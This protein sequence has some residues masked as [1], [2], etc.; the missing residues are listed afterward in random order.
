M[1]N[2]G[3]VRA[4]RSKVL[5]AYE[6]LDLAGKDWRESEQATRVI[7]AIRCGS[8]LRKRRRYRAPGTM[9]PLTRCFP[10][11]PGMPGIRRT[12]TRFGLMPGL[13]TMPGLRRHG[14]IVTAARGGT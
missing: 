2:R 10:V 12:V 9:R 13:R 1:V 6:E 11:F 8:C 3:A 5:V 14:Y 7:V 4:V